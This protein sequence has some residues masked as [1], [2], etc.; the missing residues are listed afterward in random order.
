MLAKRAFYKKYEA[1]VNMKK[2]KSISSVSVFKP[3]FVSPWLITHHKMW[4]THR[5]LI[6]R[7]ILSLGK[8]K[9]VIVSL[10]TDV[11]W[12]L[13]VCVLGWLIKHTQTAAWASQSLGWGWGQDKHAMLLSDALHTYRVGSDW[14]QVLNKHTFIEILLTTA[15]RI[16][17]KLK[18]RINE[19]GKWQETET[20]EA[21]K[22][23]QFLPSG[24]SSLP[25]V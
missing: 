21:F 12:K 5:K 3:V 4:S 11:R 18:Q 9:H 14:Q 25:L 15:I 13:P 19:T 6:W 23:L 2:Q 7:S 10:L 8:K 22:A 24:C 20:Q 1:R 17:S 16:T